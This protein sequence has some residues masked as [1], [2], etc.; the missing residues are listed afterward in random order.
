MTQWNDVC[1]IDD[2]YPDSGVCALVKGQQVAI[3]Y[4]PKEA[5]IYA[6]GNYDPIAKANIISRGMIG[7]LNGEPV[8]ASPLYKQHYNLETGICLNEDVKIDSFAVRVINDRVE[9][10]I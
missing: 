9:V 1:S 6:V 10:G 4:M 8:V 3:F 5:A 2:L 7:D